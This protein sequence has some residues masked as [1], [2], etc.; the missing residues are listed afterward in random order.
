[1]KRKLF[2]FEKRKILKIARLLLDFEIEGNDL[3]KKIEKDF[4]S[5]AKKDLSFLREYYFSNKVNYKFSHPFGIVTKKDIFK[6]YYVD[7]MLEIRNMELSDNWLEFFW[8]KPY[9]DYHLTYL[10]HCLWDHCYLDTR[11]ILK[12]KPKRFCS[13]IQLD[14]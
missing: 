7:I 10:N 14:W 1:M 6:A 11:E 13:C 2:G 8:E 9:T 5:F 3:G 12:M 4:K